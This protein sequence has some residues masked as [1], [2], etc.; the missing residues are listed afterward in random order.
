[1][2]DIINNGNQAMDEL[3]QEH[4][5]YDPRGEL[6]HNYCTDSA[7]QR[8]ET[9]RA[10]QFG[11]SDPIEEEVEQTTA[12]DQPCS[13]GLNRVEKKRDESKASPAES[14][15]MQDVALNET[16]S[17]QNNNAAISPDQ[18][19]EYMYDVDYYIPEKGQVITMAVPFS[20]IGSTEPNQKSNSNPRQGPVTKRKREISSP[21]SSKK[22]TNP[23]KR[24]R[25]FTAHENLD[26][27]FRSDNAT[28]K[29]MGSFYCNLDYFLFIEYVDEQSSES[30]TFATPTIVEVSINI[31]G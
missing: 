14:A 20:S 31:L 12:N 7:R 17:N 29:G 4:E 8:V 6:L 10:L 30:S 13:S 23:K 5:L 25:Q 2:S 11:L 27:S 26:F 22:N 3:E 28:N 21:T 15:T 16:N 24:G 1:M 9:R 18:P 19:A